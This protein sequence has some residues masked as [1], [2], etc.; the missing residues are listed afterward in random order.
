MKFAPDDNTIVPRFL[1]PLLLALLPGISPGVAVETPALTEPAIEVNRQD[2]AVV[3]DIRY[4]VPVSSREAWAVLTDFENMPGFVP[5]L[6]SSKVLRRSGSTLDVEQKGS[7]QVGMLPIHYE[8]TRRIE[9]VPYRSIRSRTLSGDT[10]LESVMALTPAGKDTLLSYH[11]TAVSN[12]PLPDSLLESYVSSMLESQF[13]AL[14]GEM[15]RRAQ[16]DGGGSSPLPAAKNR[17]REKP[18][19]GE[20]SAAPHKKAAGLTGRF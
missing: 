17:D 6:E 9:I 4:R 19:S 2:G 5:N 7:I 14:G 1:L 13:K 20:K 15:L 18:P 3:L 12:L 11:A 8:S 16:L 10:R